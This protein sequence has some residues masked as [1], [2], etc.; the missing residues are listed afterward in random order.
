[1][2]KSVIKLPR[3]TI[4]GSGSGKYDGSR[5]ASLCQPVEIIFP[6]L[7]L[8]F[9]HLH[10]PPVV[11]DIKYCPVKKRIAVK[12][13]R[14][15]IGQLQAGLIDAVGILV[16]NRRYRLFR[17]PDLLQPAIPALLQFKI[18][19]VYKLKMQQP[20]I[21]VLDLDALAFHFAT[22]ESSAAKVVLSASGTGYVFSRHRPQEN[23]P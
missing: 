6:V 23:L 19:P 16:I 8:P 2:P 12:P 20:E 14:R 18:R 1:M 3:Q 21:P 17:I 15:R 11:G 13:C 7:L 9:P 10:Q 4:A 22:G 5:L